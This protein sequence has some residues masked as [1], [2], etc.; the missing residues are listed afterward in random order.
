MSPAHTAKAVEPSI[1]RAMRKPRVR[2]SASVHQPPVMF[3][4]PASR[5]G[6]DEK[7]PLA[8]AENFSSRMRYVGSHVK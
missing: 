6:S 8:F 1:T 2:A 4:A 5:N 7:N 3:A